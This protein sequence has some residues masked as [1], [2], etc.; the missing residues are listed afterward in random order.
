MQWSLD[1]CLIGNQC[2]VNLPLY[3][4][5]CKDCGKVLYLLVKLADSDK[6]IECPHC[7]EELKKLMDAPRFFIH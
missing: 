6:K 4:Y 2:E 3:S 7:E 1:L 5:W